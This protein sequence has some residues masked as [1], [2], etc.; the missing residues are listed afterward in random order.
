MFINVYTLHL[1]N[2]VPFNCF[3]QQGRKKEN[4]SVGFCCISYMSQLARQFPKVQ[5]SR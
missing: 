3:M 5:S 1:N 4:S 2:N